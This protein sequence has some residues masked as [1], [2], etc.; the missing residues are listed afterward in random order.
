MGGEPMLRADFILELCAKLTEHGKPTLIYTNGF[1]GVTE[2]K[3]LRMLERLR[4]AGVGTIVTS[5][6]NFHSE[7]I[8]LER[9]KNVLRAHRHVPEV[10]ITVTTVESR[11]NPAEPIRE[12]LG[13]L[14]DDVTYIVQGVLEIGNARNLPDDEFT[15]PYTTFDELACPEVGLNFTGLGTVTPCPAFESIIQLPGNHPMAR[16]VSLGNSETQTVKGAL[17]AMEQPI[18][19]VLNDHGPS[20]FVSKFREAGIPEFQEPRP[21]GGP[22]QLC[23]QVFR[24]PDHFAKIENELNDYARRSK[25]LRRRTD[26]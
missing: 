6:D 14:L 7:Y 26:A 8:S 4:D 5:A 18:V 19:Q 24:N 2:A 12:E 16:V 10:A 25:P 1:W 23:V 3:A 21:V 15:K 22:C 17:E 9:V 13:D 11:S 20:W